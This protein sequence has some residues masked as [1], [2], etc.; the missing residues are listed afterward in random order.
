MEK[1]SF[2]LFEHDGLAASVRHLLQRD[3]GRAYLVGGSVRDVLLGRET[4][5]LDFVVDGDAL[6]IAR[7][8]ADRLGA[9]FYP[10][11]A[12]RRNGRCHLRRHIDPARA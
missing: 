8:V 12:R 2:R 6:E 11:D 1:I 3:A 9:P 7:N 5:D 10:L 4:H